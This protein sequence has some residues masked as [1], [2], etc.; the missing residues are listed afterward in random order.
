MVLRLARKLLWDLENLWNDTYLAKG[1]NGRLVHSLVP[2][3][4]AIGRSYSYSDYEGV[5][6]GSKHPSVLGMELNLGLAQVE[7]LDFSS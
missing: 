1:Y 3:L 2:F 7:D 4:S 5:G 6:S